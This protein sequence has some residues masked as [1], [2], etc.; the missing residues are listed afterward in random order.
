MKVKATLL[1]VLLLMGCGREIA[2]AADVFAAPPE[3]YATGYDWSGFYLGAAGGWTIDGNAHYDIPSARDL[4]LD[5][6]LGGPLLG[7]Q[8]GYLYQTG[9]FFVG[10]ELQGLWSGVEG[11]EV[12]WD[13]LLDTHT[14]VDWLAMGKLKGG[15]AFDRFS[16]FATGGYAGADVTA[17]AGFHYCAQ[18]G[19]C[20]TTWDD[21]EWLNGF[22]YGLGAAVGVNDYL[23]IGVEWNHVQLNEKD[24]SDTTKHGRY[25]GLPVT[26]NGDLDLDVI[27]A[28]ANFHF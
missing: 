17:D 10:A 22:V 12:K 5:H 13:G 19:N 8:L 20:T 21:S 15:L 1:T 4:D 28:T 16:V 9:W 3:Q 24:F 7:G 27:L 18:Q 11:D 14:D 6:N 23:R 26:A 25:A 2:H